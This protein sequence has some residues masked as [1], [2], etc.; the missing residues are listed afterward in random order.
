MALD[1]S[2][3]LQRVEIVG[4]SIR[5]YRHLK[6]HGINTFLDLARAP[7]E[8]LEPYF[9]ELRAAMLRLGRLFAGGHMCYDDQGEEGKHDGMA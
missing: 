5:C 6:Q 1:P 2:V 3:L 4:L 8:V 9:A 7:D